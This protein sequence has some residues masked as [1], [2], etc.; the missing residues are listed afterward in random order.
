[1]RFLPDTGIELCYDMSQEIDCPDQGE[2][3]YGQDAQYATNPMSFADNGDGTVTDNVT[4]LMWQQEDDDVAKPWWDALAYCEDLELAGH[5]SWRLP[6]EYELQGIVYYGWRNSPSIDAAYFPGMDSDYYWSSSIYAG[7]TDSAWRVY[8]LGGVYYDYIT[9]SMH[10]L[11]VREEPTIPSFTDNGDGTVTD[12]VTGLMW[13]KEN[14]HVDRDWEDALAYCEDSELAGRTD[15]R[16]PDIKEI[17]SI[18]DNTRYDPAIDTTYF[19]YTASYYYWSSSTYAD[20]AGSA[21]YVSITNGG[22]YY[23]YKTHYKY[24]QCV[25]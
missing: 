19:P 3:F 6:D 4:G 14:D 12:N 7:R 21:W 9:N 13:Q 16:L 25:R 17:R 23:S 2:P 20:Y 11:C 10:V 18:V 1:M 15:W 5:T 24:V 22:V 8:F